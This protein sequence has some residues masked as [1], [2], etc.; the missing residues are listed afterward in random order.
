MC[1][2]D[3]CGGAGKMVQG[4]NQGVIRMEISNDRC[5]ISITTKKWNVRWYMAFL[6]WGIDKNAHCMWSVRIKLPHWSIGSQLKLWF[7]WLKKICYKFVGP[8]PYDIQR[9]SLILYFWY[10]FLVPTKVLWKERNFVYILTFLAGWRSELAGCRSTL[11]MK[12]N[13][14]PFTRPWF[15][16]TPQL[17]NF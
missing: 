1:I 11:S 15:Q 13:F 6:H 2:R 14:S 10:D 7:D 4:R 8:P 12:K 16:P 5:I 9:W 17:A 3:R